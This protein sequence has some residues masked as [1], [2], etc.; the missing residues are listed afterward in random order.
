MSKKIFLTGLGTWVVPADWNNAN[1][2][3]ECIGAGGDGHGGGG[4]NAVSG[5]GGG[6]YAAKSN[7]T[8]TGTIN[9]RSGVHSTLAATTAGDTWFNGAS[10]AGAEVSAQGGKPGN[11]TAAGIGGKASNSIGTTK[12]NGGDGGLTGGALDLD[13]F[14]NTGGGGGGAAGP[15]GTGKMGGAGASVHGE[16]GGGGGGGANGG[17]AGSD[18]AGSG[19]A[20]GGTV[21]G[22][23]GGQASAGTAGTADAVFDATNGPGGGGGG[24]GATTPGG[25]PGP[26]VAGGAGGTYGGGG[27]GGT[28]A[29]M[30]G[31]G[32]IVITYDPLPA[33]PGGGG[34][35]KKPQSEK[36][37]KPKK[38]HGNRE[39]ADF[40]IAQDT[41][42]AAA[43]AALEP[44]APVFVTGL[45]AEPEINYA[46]VQQAMDSA[47]SALLAAHEA[48]RQV[49]QRAA[50]AWNAQVAKQHAQWDQN[51]KII[52][53]VNATLAS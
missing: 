29:G 3:V 1:N 22:G 42:F 8:L 32:V 27:G 21:G 25:A 37:G 20:A 52:A 41:P 18:G 13:F 28:V 24:S 14:D 9:Y 47:G 49:N 31:A 26:S 5:G 11:A 33:S 53:I 43:V 46:R 34:G 7:L 50:H 19:F 2:S 30:G 40:T 16:L 39:Q 23:A 4:D 12:F 35:G 10:L 51:A 44:P 45:D 15:G 48:K 17:T 38:P 36:P 6:A